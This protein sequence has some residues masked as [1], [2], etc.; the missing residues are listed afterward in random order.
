MALGGE[1][2]GKEGNEGIFRSVLFERVVEG[3][4]A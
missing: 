1:S 2:I 3:E 4:N